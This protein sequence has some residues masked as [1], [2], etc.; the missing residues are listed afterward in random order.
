MNHIGKRYRDDAD[1]YP[2]SKRERLREGTLF[3]TKAGYESYLKKRQQV[4]DRFGLISTA[5]TD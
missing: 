5:Q 2:L 1:L 3:Y 4:C